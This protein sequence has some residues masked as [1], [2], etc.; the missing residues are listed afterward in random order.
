M[1]REI[2]RAERDN[3]K[4]FRSDRTSKSGISWSK[5]SS[6]KPLTDGSAPTPNPEYPFFSEFKI[7]SLQRPL[8]TRYLALSPATVKNTLLTS[9]CYCRRKFGSA[10]TH[11]RQTDFF[12]SS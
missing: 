10:V 3:E 12:H 2:A 8:K 11:P 1:L 7:T 6:T 5:S 9:D 4:P